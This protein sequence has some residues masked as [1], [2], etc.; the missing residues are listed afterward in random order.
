M[1]AAPLAGFSTRSGLSG[2]WSAL[3]QRFLNDER[4]F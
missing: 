3:D 2:Q 4:F 1:P